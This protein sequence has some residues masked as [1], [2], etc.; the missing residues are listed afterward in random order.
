M[1]SRFVPWIALPAIVLVAVLSGCAA[2]TKGPSSPAATPTPHAHPTP[3]QAAAPSL[4]VPLKCADLFTPGVISGLVDTPVTLQSDESAGPVDLEQ[5][6]AAQRGSLAC[7]WGGK[8]RTD[9]GYDQGLTLYV[10]ADGA[11]GYATNIPILEADSPPTAENTAGD[12]SEYVCEA[13]TDFQCSANMLV[14]DFWVSAYIQNLGDSTISADVANTR[15]QQVLSTI[16]T[17]L[18]KVKEANAWTPPGPALPAFCSDPNSIAKLDSILGGIALS[19]SSNDQGGLDAQSI[20]ESGSNF[21]QC[22]WQTSDSGEAGTGHFT[23]IDIGMLRGGAWALK[24]LTAAPPTDWYLGAYKP[25]TVTGASATVLACNGTDCAAIMAI[26]TI[27]VQV[28]LDD[29]GNPA[30]ELSTLGSVVAAIAASQPN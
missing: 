28:N 7:I 2:P 17:A 24:D 26:G 25:V 29:I 15:I 14:G 13:T 9:G 20:A 6:A 21:A 27:A 19:P 12:K 10:A 11:S 5:I 1:T 8:N 3:T 22:S 30:K 16:A 18:G 23:Y 4:R